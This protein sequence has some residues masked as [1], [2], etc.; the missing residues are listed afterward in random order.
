MAR[1][2][3]FHI[4]LISAVLASAVL[5]VFEF[6]VRAISWVLERLPFLADPCPLADLFGRPT[7]ALVGPPD[8]SIAPALAHEQRHEA[9]LAR[10]GTVRHR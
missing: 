9:G 5:W 3:F 7:L 6:P 10:L 2:R 8:C 1:S 4:S